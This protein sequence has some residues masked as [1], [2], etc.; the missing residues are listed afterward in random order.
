MR[1]TRLLRSLFLLALGCVLGGLFVSAWEHSAAFAQR[2]NAAPPAPPTMQD[3]QHLKDIIPPMSHPMVDVAFNA[4][5]LWFAGQKKNWPLANYFLGETRN[6][7]RWETNLNPG[8]K[9]TDGNPVDMKAT[10]DGIDKGSLTTLKAA[11]DKKDSKMFVDEYKH[12]LEDCYS[13]HKATNRSYM[14]P[15]IPTAAAQT[16]IN[17]DP[18]ATWPE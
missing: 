1:R 16:I 18:A 14:R 11:I 2:D 10:F 4:T 5:N 6:R 9:G 3:V 12:L 13:C 15:Q 8:P 7:M 17:T